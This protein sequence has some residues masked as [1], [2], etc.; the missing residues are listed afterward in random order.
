[1]IKPDFSGARG[2]NAGDNFHELWALRQS[3]SLLDP[4][5]SL[6]AI[7]VE[8]L[9]AKDE[10]GNPESW[11][12]VDCS[13]YFGG[14]D[15]SSVEEIIIEQLKYSSSNPEKPWTIARLTYSK[16]KTKNNSILRKLANAFSEL[17]KTHPKLIEDE[18]L[19]IRFVSNQ[20]VDSSLI[21]ALSKTKSLKKQSKNIPTE[22]TKLIEASGLETEDFISFAKTLDFSQCGKES[23]FAV[24]ERILTTISE[25]TEDDARTSVN[26]LLAFI[27]RKMLPEA[28]G[29]FI[30]CQ[31]ILAQLGFSDPN[32]LF[33]CLTT[34]KSI[35]NLVPEVAEKPLPCKSLKELCPKALLLLSMI[36][37]AK[38]TT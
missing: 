2:S 31:S 28:K 33:P 38:V 37:M 34:I 13:Y 32:A 16:S 20:P 29:E 7:A 10:T 23:R 25:W 6:N 17:N 24:E 21:D 3:L 26:D 8:G 14:D 1:M 18:N 15:I 36:V 11:D 4:N 19:E 9:I 5:T 22:L 27:R 35:S 30:T 12:G